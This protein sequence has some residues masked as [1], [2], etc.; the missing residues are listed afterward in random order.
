MVECNN[1]GKEVKYVYKGRKF[2]NRKCQMEYRVEHKTMIGEK[3]PNWKGGVRWSKGHKLI[4][5]PH[6][7][8]AD[9]K[10]YMLEH[11]AV[12]ELHLGRYLTKKEAVHHKNEVRDDNRIENLKL[13]PTGGEHS[14]FHFLGKKRRNR[15][16]RNGI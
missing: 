15:N 11:R 4:Y 10:G 6:H 14:R 2:C 7:P 8:N 9:K 3:N 16:G 13:F 1:C 5:M 12:M